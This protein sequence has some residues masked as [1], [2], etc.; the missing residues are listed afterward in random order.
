M[1]DST[2]KTSPVIIDGKKTAADIRAELSEEIKSLQAEHG[3]TPGL[4]VVLVGQRVDSATYVRMK[5]KAAAEIGIH[6][7]DV[8]VDEDISEEALIAEIQKLND[9][10]EV[11]GILVQLPLPSHINEAKVLKTIEYEKDADG[12]DAT[13]IGNMWL[14][15]GEPPL[16]I[17]C[18]PAG[19][20][21]L[22]Q[23]YNIE[24]SGK[25]CVVLGR[26]NIVGMPVAALL[27][28][29]NGTVTVC[30]SRTKNIPEIVGRAD[31]VIAAIGKTEFVRGEWLKP[32]VVVIDVGINDKPD[33]TKKR[34]YRLVGDVNYEEA[35]EKASA[36]TPVP[37]GVGPMTIAMLMKNTVNLC[38][39]SL[40]LPR[41]QLRDR[42]KDG[43]YQA[44][45]V[46]NTTPA[47][48]EK[49]E[50]TKEG[51]EKTTCQ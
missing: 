48:T 39:H 28:S 15:G 8:T 31:I 2:T 46:V 5:K 49:K 44:H 7:I 13:N 19:C 36:I 26:S 42:S 14:R 10:P 25:E 20:I 45:K 35:I 30:H 41:L 33:A 43:D 34:G 27:T 16:A 17:P 24:I 47:A 3:T 51:E 50:E 22:L 37:G 6:S 18:T 11:H 4:A 1:A 40:G 32:G 9:D 29:C 23:R 21:E 38:R 12:F